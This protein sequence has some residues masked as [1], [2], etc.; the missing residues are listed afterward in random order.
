MDPDRARRIL[1]EFKHRSLLVLGDLMLDRYVWGSVARISPEA[2]VPVVE[3]EREES[4]PGGAA[5]VA[6]N[7]RVFAREVHLIGRVG[8]DADGSELRGLLEADGIRMDNL[9]VDAG[10]PTIVK[11][12]ILARH[13]QVVRVDRERLSLLDSAAVDRI[14]A[15]LSELL[16]SVDGVVLEDYG[17]GLFTQEVAD[18]VIALCRSAGK[19]VAVDPNPRNPIRWRDATVVKPNRPEAFAA[20]RK[21]VS[22]PVQPPTEDRELLEAGRLLMEEWQCDQLLITLGE[23][24]MML[25]RK[26]LPPYHSAS[27]A[28]EVYDVSGAGDTAISTLALCLASG[29]EPEEAAELANHAAGIV[30]AKLGTAT[31]TLDELSRSFEQE[32]D[33][34]P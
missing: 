5:N 26:G 34:R 3:V 20:A 2:P 9:L 16:P 7:L 10:F 25:F 18:R 31:V 32:N 6:R 21:P 30:V 29:A 11:T 12:R 15:T 23:D 13:Q 22:K 27:K 19:L 17:K 28:R 24:G 1:S 33:G 4:F 8:E 14:C